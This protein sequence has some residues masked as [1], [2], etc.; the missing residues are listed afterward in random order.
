MGVHSILTQFMV[1]QHSGLGGVEN[2]LYGDENASGDENEASGSIKGVGQHSG[3]GGVENDLYG[4]ENASGDENEASGEDNAASGDE[5][6]A[7]A[8]ENDNVDGVE[9]IMDDEHIIDQVDVN[10][11]RFRFIA[12]SYDERDILRPQVNMNEDDLQVIDY[13]EFKSEIDE[14][15]IGSTKRSA[16][17]KLR[18][19]GNASNES[20]I[21]NHFFLGQEFSNREEVKERI[22]AYSV[23]SRRNVEIMKN[24]NVRVRAR[25]VAIVPRQLLTA[26]SV[27]ANNGI[28]LVAYGIVESES[29]DSWLWFLSTLGDDLDLHINLNFTFIIDKQKKRKK[30]VVELDELVKGVK[31]SKKGPTVTCSNFKGKGHNKRDCKTNAAGR[32]AGASGS[33]AASVTAT[34]QEPA[35]SQQGAAATQEADSSASPFKRTKSTAC[36]HT[37][38]K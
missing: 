30:S 22:K 2:D 34:H 37:P 36:R 27:D 32:A 25:C 16:H 12:N 14:D 20:G 9:D 6:Y 7:T 8:D 11:E 21:M 28:Y 13:N 18:K 35:A 10:M 24:D 33:Q 26:V 17:R 23:E 29:L 5:N 19:K 4:D 31:L 15:D 38:T 3:L 1:G